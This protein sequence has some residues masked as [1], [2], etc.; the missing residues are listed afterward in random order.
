LIHQI[1]NRHK[2]RYNSS[3][4]KDHIREEESFSMLAVVFKNRLPLMMV[5][6]IFPRFLVW[7]LLSTTTSFIHQ[8]SIASAQTTTAIE[9]QVEGEVPLEIQISHNPT[10]GFRE[11]YIEIQGPRFRAPGQTSDNE[12][13]SFRY[14]EYS[15]LSA[16]GYSISMCV[17]ED[18][19]LT[20]SVQVLTLFDY[21][22]EMIHELYRFLPDEV[23]IIY[24]GEF[25]ADKKGPFPYAG[26]GV[27]IVAELGNCEIVC[28]SDETL[29]ELETV[30]INA[31]F[32]WR[33]FD[34]AT[35]E[36]AYT[37]PDEISDNVGNPR[38]Y[39]S[40]GQYYHERMC[41][42]K[43]G[44]FALVAGESNLQEF[45]WND[46]PDL[47]NVTF[48]GI[49]VESFDNIQF[50]AIAL[51]APGEASTG[52]CPSWT[53]CENGDGDSDEQFHLLEMFLFRD[54]VSREEAS[55]M[56]WSLSS[57]DQQSQVVPIEGDLG[58]GT[59]QSGDRALQYHRECV[60][61][62]NACIRFDLRVLPSETT[63]NV[64][65]YG[66][67]D[68]YRL[69]VDGVVYGEGEYQF[70]GSTQDSSTFEHS[71]YV[72]HCTASQVCSS[73]EALLQVDLVTGPRSPTWDSYDVYWALYNHCSCQD[74]NN[75]WRQD[76]MLDSQISYV[77]PDE[78]YRYLYCLDSSYLE[79]DDSCTEAFVGETGLDN[80]NL[81]QYSISVDNEVFSERRR[82]CDTSSFLCEG[83]VG[84]PIGGDCEEPRLT[85]SAIIG[86]AIGGAVMLLLCALAVYFYIK[87]SKE[88]P[89]CNDAASRPVAAAVGPTE[90][91]IATPMPMAPAV[92][93]PREDPERPL[94]SN[95]GR[96]E[97][98]LHVR[99]R[100]QNDDEEFA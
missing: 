40:E 11:N 87:K 74:R 48:G 18:Q 95:S 38:C 84:T 22:S 17:P 27:Q 32:D 45:V 62:N 86:L 24:N 35:G 67:S 25:I 76:D 31:S 8:A 6:R 98:G 63:P 46:N 97:S 7:L 85:Q 75:D 100:I 91:V 69:V 73:S 41:L 56:T 43:S 55:I 19:C 77:L 3:Q 94:D 71:Q 72:G 29:L 65:Y 36:V 57:M 53:S 49:L 51:K 12:V 90:E 89:Q 42:P 10:E 13:E 92:E 20:A 58:M 79:D 23:S 14:F 66:E 44:C 26:D 52:S 83:Y 28:A 5:G 21:G 47:L 16:N 93:T 80:G 81:A 9:C 60:P 34:Y 88:E 61:K 78:S 68:T 39:W 54:D 50:E 59:I 70:G 1:S 99:S 33:V 4:E 15:I 96:G 82:G 64:H 30:S 37:C 2:N